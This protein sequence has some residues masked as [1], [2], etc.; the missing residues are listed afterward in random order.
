MNKYRHNSGRVPRVGIAAV[1]ACL[2]VLAY[3]NFRE[4]SY[5]DGELGG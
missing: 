4:D 5:F 3:G 2:A 1:F